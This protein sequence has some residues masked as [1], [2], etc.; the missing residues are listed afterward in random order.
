MVAV[1]AP[2]WPD[3]RVGRVGMAGCRWRVSEWDTGVELMQ[4]WKFGRR[5]RP[6]FARGFG[7]NGLASVLQLVGAV[8][9]L[10]TL[11]SNG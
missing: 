10:E 6:A 9:E 8:S 4:E 3:K 7:G 11:K 2:L 5:V 1:V